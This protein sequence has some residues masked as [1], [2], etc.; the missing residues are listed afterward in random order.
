MSFEVASFW[1]PCSFFKVIL[2]VEQPKG[3]DLYSYL[4]M[5][6]GCIAE[7]FFYQKD[8]VE[9]QMIYNKAKELVLSFIISL[10]KLDT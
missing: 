7:V 9:K 3:V 2:F 8:R 6:I 4:E 1:E 10:V 5:S